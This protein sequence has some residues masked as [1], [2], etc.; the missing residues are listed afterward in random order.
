MLSLFPPSS[1]TIP[2]RS[3]G[4]FIQKVLNFITFA[5]DHV[6]CKLQV[7]TC[8]VWLL[9]RDVET[10]HNKTA[11]WEKRCQQYVCGHNRKKP[12]TRLIP[13]AMGWSFHREACKRA[14]RLHLA[15][16]AWLVTGQIFSPFIWSHCPV[17]CYLRH[18]GFIILINLP[19]FA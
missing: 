18:W 5:A 13:G 4:A 1:S 19:G 10:T 2:Q 9:N 17:L 8:L 14:L 12:I 15:W 6:I 16:H 11:S 7:W 3:L